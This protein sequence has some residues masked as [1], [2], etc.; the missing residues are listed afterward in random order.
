MI[1]VRLKVYYKCE[2]YVNC[3]LEV[4]YCFNEFCFDFYFWCY[5]FIY[6]LV[7]FFIDCVYVNFYVNLIIIL[8]FMFNEY[9]CKYSLVDKNFLFLRKIRYNYIGYVI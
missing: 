9:I 1:N 7:Q 6:F 5:L 2:E 4:V 8:V 3:F